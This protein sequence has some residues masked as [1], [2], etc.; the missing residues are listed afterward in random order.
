VQAVAAAAPSLLLRLIGAWLIAFLMLV[1]GFRFLKPRVRAR[2]MRFDEK[3]SGWA[4]G[5][6]YRE[7]IDRR[8][9]RLWLT[10]FFRFWTN[11]ASS[12]SLIVLSF[13]I[14]LWF[15]LFRASPITGKTPEAPPTFA[16]IVRY[17]LSNNV[18][19]WM[20][21]GLCFCGALLLSFVLKRVFR[22]LR[23]PRPD[24]A[25]GHKLKDPSFPS[26]HS[27]TSFCFWMMLAIS[28][29]AALSVTTW[30]VLFALLAVSVVVLTG[31]SRVYLGVHFASDVIG[32][33]IIGFVWSSVCYLLLRGTFVV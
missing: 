3:A 25:F 20:L 11:F 2:A 16:Q 5:L 8:D 1:Y 7:H 23:P 14:P 18:E 31:M 17:T 28:T 21:P 12:P 15:V 9:E 32:G 19:L 33:F 4:R 13:L 24:G 27:L 30:T 29:F 10:W 26:G 22:R 6:R